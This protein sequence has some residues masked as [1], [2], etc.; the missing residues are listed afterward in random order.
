LIER[1]TATDDPAPW[2]HPHYRSFTATTSRSASTTRDGT[3]ALT[4]SAAWDTPSRPPIGT[5]SIGSCLLTFH[6]EAADQARVA[7]MPDTAWPVSGLPPDSSR[8][9]M[10][11]PVSM[12]PVTISTR[13]RRFAYARLP[14]P[15]LTRLARLF[16]IAHHERHSTPAACGGLKP[17]PTGRPRRA[18]TFIICAAPL[19]EA[20]PTSSSLPRS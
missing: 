14:D 20:L 19:H 7:S 5:D 12:S 1:P 2:L 9:R 8:D 16:H 13:Q 11:T 17:P 18:T 10:D 6:A 4:V 15:H 3:H